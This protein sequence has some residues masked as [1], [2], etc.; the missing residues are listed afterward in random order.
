MAGD[1][2]DAELLP[3]LAPDSAI[4]RVALPGGLAELPITRAQADALAAP[5]DLYIG[6]YSVGVRAPS[7]EDFAPAANWSDDVR[8]EMGLPTRRR[9]LPPA[10]ALGQPLRM[11]TRVGLAKLEPAGR[12]HRATATIIRTSFVTHFSIGNRKGGILLA[13]Q[14][15][16][17]VKV[18]GGHHLTIGIALDP[19]PVDRLT[20]RAMARKL[21]GDAHD[22]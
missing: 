3:E 13:G 10:P 4:M 8:R 9:R 14:F 12:T 18:L 1:I 16:E 22:D 19:E 21:L 20:L 7:V 5:H 17:P 15:N 11:G 2:I 6:F